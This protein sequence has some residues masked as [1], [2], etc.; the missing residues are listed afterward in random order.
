MTADAIWVRVYLSC[1]LANAA[2]GE[3]VDAIAEANAAV[4]AL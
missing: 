2:T 3:S 1:L 4:G